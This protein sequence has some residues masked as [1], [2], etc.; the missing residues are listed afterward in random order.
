M[1]KHLNVGLFAAFLLTLFSCARQGTPS[2][3]PK[4]ETPPVFIKSFPDTLATNVDPNIK[5]IK[6]H[7]DEYIQL[8]D[9]NK[10]A[11]VSPPFEKNPI[12]SPLTMAEKYVTIKLQEPLQPNTTYSFNFG[13]A[14]QDFN[15]NNKLSNFNYVFSTGNYIDSLS[16]KGKVF[17]GIDFKL[18]EKVLVG[19][20]QYNEN[21]NDSIPL[22][23]KPYYISRV[24]EKGE[25]DLKYLREGKYKIIAFEDAIENSKFDIAKEKVAFTDQIIDLDNPKEVNL[26]LF[27]P[28]KSYR[29]EKITQKGVGHIVL[30]TIGLEEPLKISLKDKSF[31]TLMIDQH[32]TKDSVNIWFN[33]NVDKIEGRN[34]RLTFE[35]DYKGKI[36]TQT[37]LYTNSNQEYKPT[38]KSE[39][40]SKLSPNKD[41]SIIGSAPIKS[42]NKSLINVFKDTIPVQFDAIIDSVNNQKINFKFDKNL[43]E[44]F[45]VN[46]YP[47]AIIDLFDAPNDTLVY[48]INM[49]SRE[50]FGNLKVRINN[51]ESN[52]IFVQLIKNSKDFEVLEEV[53]STNREFYFPNITPGEYYLRV[54]VDTNKNG[55]WDSGDYL[56]QLQP[57]PSYIYPNK[58]IIRALWDSDET[59]IIGKDSE[60]FILLPE[61][62][63]EDKNKQNKNVNLQT[64]R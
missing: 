58:L 21:Y 17:P 14:I 56:S 36:D 44:N 2:G 9:Y 49:G 25:F 3:G 52:P 42:I 20:Y 8:K 28:K 24:N 40:E 6:I 38:Y 37:V 31:S 55:I 43:K 22:Q 53:Y 54:L 61:V 48:Q 16:L 11:V 13:D 4:D 41:F 64:N 47:K 7:F 5:E 12:V 26:K 63:E 33:P 60:N 19:L 57:E 45:E 46:I 39:Q 27:R 34:E 35:I 30:K 50:D 15:E 10:N 18:P 59:W 32:P 23:S 1:K 51:L 29:I 62:K